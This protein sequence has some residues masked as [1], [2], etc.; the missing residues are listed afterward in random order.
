MPVHD[1]IILVDFMYDE[2][3]IKLQDYPST[4]I[5]FHYCIRT[6]KTG[7]KAV[8]YI[9]IIILLI[10]LFF[11]QTETR[12]RFFHRFLSEPTKRPA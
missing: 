3:V 5:L 4:I 7:G 10:L 12:Q 1:S 9:K 11:F 8:I 2:K 6:A